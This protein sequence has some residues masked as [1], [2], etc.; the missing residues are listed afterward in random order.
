MGYKIR[1]LLVLIHSFLRHFKASQ[2]NM[3]TTVVVQ[4]HVFYDK[5]LDEKTSVNTSEEVANG[6]LP[7]SSEKET[8]VAACTSIKST[9]SINW[10]KKQDEMDRRQR[11]FQYFLA[12]RRRGRSDNTEP[13]SDFDGCI[14]VESTRTE[15]QKKQQEE[16]D[17][18][19]RV[20]LYFLAQQRRGRSNNPKPELEKLL[21]EQ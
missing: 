17:R 5:I 12:Q 16:M 7:F 1:V 4:S 10:R 13:K 11:V 19:Q 9:S 6:F 3:S 8:D 14:A 21:F 18:R 15:N 20:F 2:S